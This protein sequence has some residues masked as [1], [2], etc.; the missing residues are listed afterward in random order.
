LIRITHFGPK[1]H[2]QQESARNPSRGRARM[3]RGRTPADP[4]RERI[5][6]SNVTAR[7]GL[8]HA[9]FALR[10]LLVS[11][12]RNMAWMLAV[13]I[14][15]VRCWWR[16]LTG[17]AEHQHLAENFPTTTDFRSATPRAKPSNRTN[18]CAASTAQYIEEQVSPRV[19][20]CRTQIVHVACL[21]F[22]LFSR[23][24]CMLSSQIRSA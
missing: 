3:V 8:V 18:D 2:Q 6:S 5:V 22:S 23:P 17:C 12:N 20:L 9:N 10:H 15:D 13:H 1:A 16:R 11:R 7:G 19:T 24:W 4:R 21:N 14:H